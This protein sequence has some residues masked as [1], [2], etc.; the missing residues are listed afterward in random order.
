MC[1]ISLVKGRPHKRT[2]RWMKIVV[3]DAF[4]PGWVQ[5]ARKDGFIESAGR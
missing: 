1:G 5:E 4:V 2:N 3:G